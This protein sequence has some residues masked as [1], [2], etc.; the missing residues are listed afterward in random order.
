MQSDL[1]EEQINNNNEFGAAYICK[2]AS[3]GTWNLAQRLQ[4]TTQSSCCILLVIGCRCF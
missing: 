2:Q 3:N 4:D 1:F